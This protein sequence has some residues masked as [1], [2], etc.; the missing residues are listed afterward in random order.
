[1][2]VTVKDKTYKFTAFHNNIAMVMLI[3]AV[4]IG[5]HA[6]GIIKDLLRVK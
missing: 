5:M 1:M 4:A 2:E 3:T 6:F